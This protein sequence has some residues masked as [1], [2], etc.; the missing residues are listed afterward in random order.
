MKR[1][2]LAVMLLIAVLAGCLAGCGKAQTGE[3]DAPSETGSQQ[4]G[5]AQ[6]T[7][8]QVKRMEA[9]TVTSKYAYQAEYIDLPVK[10]D[11]IQSYSISG[12]SLWFIGNVPAGKESYVDETTGESYE[13][14]TYESQLFRMDMMTQECTQLPLPEGSEI[15]EGWEGSSY[16][17]E[18]CAGTDG[19][20]WLYEQMNTYRFN[21][22]EGT[23]LTP[24]N[25][26]DYYENGE[27]AAALIHL[28]D[29]G[30]VLKRIPIEQGIDG[31]DFYL[32]YFIVDS[33]G[34][35]YA[36]NWQKILVWDKDGNQIASLDND[37][38][39]LVQY[40]ADKVGVF[41]YGEKNS[42]KV[43]DPVKKDWGETIELP[44]LAYQIQPGDDVYDFFYDYNGK[45][46]GYISETDT[47][48]K[49]VDWMECDV[50]SN[51]M[52]AYKI[53]P[54]GRVFAFTQKWTEDG[55][56][57]QII[58][59]TRVDASTLPEKTTLTLACMY[60]DYNLRSQIVKFNQKNQQYRIVVKDYSDYNTENDYTAGLTK[61]T[62]EIASG[63]MPDLLLTTSLPV[64]QYAAKGL[65]MD[66]NPLFDSGGLSRD[67]LVTELLD[68][69]SIDGKLYQMP[70]S[71]QLGS[72][73]GLQKVVGDYETWTLEDVKD[74]MTKLQ[75][76]A[77]IFSQ[78]YTKD[79][80]LS[81]CISVNFESFVNWE[82]G[83]CNFDSDEFKSLLAF[84]NEFPDEFDYNTATTE[85]YQSEYSRLK[86]GQQLLMT[87]GFYGFDELYAQFKMLDDQ[88][89]F[90]GFP[91]TASGERVR[92]FF[93][94]DTAIAITAACTNTDAAW[95]FIQSALG[96][97]YQSQLWDLPVLKSA[98]DAKLAEA[99]KQDFYTDENGNL[100]ESSKG[101]IGYGDDETI[102]IYAVTEE[103]KNIFMDLL[104]STTKVNSYDE[105]I[106]SIITE[107]TGAYFAG[108][109]TVDEV[110][111]VIQNRANLYIAEQR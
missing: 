59:L 106:M 42:I 86:S 66:L 93:S 10:V 16:I 40:S 104:H 107:E 99:M 45:I 108:Q 88:P 68:A 71:F 38:D 21:A 39:Q 52:Q 18:M 79:N 78:Y 35:V 55:T 75:P 54:D 43:F 101:G 82:N 103:Q 56:Q 109:K 57:T 5:S 74:A 87:M 37:G 44:S 73:V 34:Y 48:E 102:E 65:L 91:T 64:Q 3:T 62:T 76:E 31:Q 4:G 63:S 95:A 94:P 92:S 32:N 90:V 15:P 13:Y 96:E 60:L 61:L 20:I 51:D 53:L 12:S 47:A 30:E 23:E 72:V 28:S 69:M 89:C 26:Y 17:Q 36:G 58:L 105:N 100:V 11:Y 29:S 98:F 22:P 33:N 77:T 7:N 50:D 25:Q 1:R 84:A 6:K 46:Y 9:D 27:A 110:A 49:V 111:K 67:D 14:D 19:T 97:E 70:L 81:T 80:I 8:A 2:I 85:V 24:E 41:T 83:T